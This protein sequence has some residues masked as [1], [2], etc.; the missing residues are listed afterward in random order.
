MRPAFASDAC[1]DALLAARRLS[2]AGS[3]CSPRTVAHLSRRRPR[4]ARRR[5]LHQLRAI[6]GGGA[7]PA[8]C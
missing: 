7:A 6:L 4:A 5:Q 2:D 3:Q 8:L 1:H